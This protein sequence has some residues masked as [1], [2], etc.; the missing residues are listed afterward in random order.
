VRLDATDERL[1][2]EAPAAAWSNVV[3]KPRVKRSRT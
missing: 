1:V 2:R 3:P